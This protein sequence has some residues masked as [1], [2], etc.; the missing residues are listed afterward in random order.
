MTPAIST[1]ADAAQRWLWRR[2]IHVARS[3]PNRFAA[4]PALLA[5]LHARGYQPRAVIDGGANVGR[6]TSIA[7]EHFPGAAFK[8]IEPQ[9]GCA[10]FLSELARRI[11]LAT[12]FP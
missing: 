9:P 10:P 8:L 4:I 12:T 5:Q 1:I 2:G 3:A 11:G 6:F 7:H